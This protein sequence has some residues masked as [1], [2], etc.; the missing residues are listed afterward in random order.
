VDRV[1]AAGDYTIGEKTRK[2]MPRGFE[3]PAERAEFLLYEGLTASIRL[4]ASAALEP[5]F[6]ERCV[7]HFAAMW[8]IGEWLLAELGA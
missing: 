2:L 8:P 1:R 6:S 7:A 5:G 3:A 4:P